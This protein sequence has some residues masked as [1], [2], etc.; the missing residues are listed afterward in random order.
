MSRVS[1]VDIHEMYLTADRMFRAAEIVRRRVRGVPSPVL[2]A[3]ASELLLKTLIYHQSNRVVR[4][5]NLERLYDQLHPET[6]AMLNDRFTSNYA[7]DRQY[8]RWVETRTPPIP[9]HDLTSVLR[10]NANIFELGRYIYEV[11]TL[12]SYGLTLLAKS[13][14]QITKAL[15]YGDQNH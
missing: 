14:R 4:G 13:L 1:N 8:R 5:H 11:D 3:L 2:F 15:L 6:Q 7:Q 12:P 10:V 9:R